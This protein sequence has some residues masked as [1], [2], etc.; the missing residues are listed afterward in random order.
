MAMGNW[1]SLGAAGIVALGWFVTGWL[2]RRKD[3]AQKRLEHR[4]EALKSFLPVWFLIQQNGASF[5]QPE[6]LAANF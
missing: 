1:I 6:F 4:L 2:N 3:V 5:Q